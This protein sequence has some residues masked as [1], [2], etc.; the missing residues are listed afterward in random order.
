MQPIDDN[1]LMKDGLS[2]KML[3]KLSYHSNLNISLKKN[4]HYF[5]KELLFEELKRINKWYDASEYLCNLT[6]DYR[7]KSIQS[8]F[9]K[10]ERYYPDHQTAKVFNDML[11]FR[12]LCDNYMNILLLKDCKHIRIADMSE[13][14]AQDDGYR[15]VH[16]YFQ[17]DNFH[18]PIE[19]QYNTYYDRQ[20][21]NWLH[22]Y[23]YKKSYDNSIGQYLR[24]AYENAEIR[25]ENEFRRKL[26]DVLS[27]CEKI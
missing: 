5:D 6:I 2:L 4:L 16:A 10:Y 17:L 1:I 7:I 14:K 24:Q 22:K 23:L 13:G 21:N 25:N 11:G 20:I 3:E 15:G 27:D 18:Y 9:L 19:I 26:K 12:T 8:A